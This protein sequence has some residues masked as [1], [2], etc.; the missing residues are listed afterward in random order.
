[1]KKTM[2]VALIALVCFGCAPVM[3]GSMAATVG[4][5][6][7]QMALMGE[8]GMFQDSVSVEFMEPNPEALKMVME[9]GKELGY[10]V[11]KPNRNMVMLTKGTS[12]GAMMAGAVTMGIAQPPVVVITATLSEDKKRIDLSLTRHGKTSN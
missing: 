8:R 2:F 11:Q 9:A 6:A 3:L 12:T 5:S 10:S 7:G 1:M 4:L